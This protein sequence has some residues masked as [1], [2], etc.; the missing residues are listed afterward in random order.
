MQHYSQNGWWLRLMSSFSHDMQDKK[1]CIVIL[2]WKKL[3]RATANSKDRT[4]AWV[5]SEGNQM[6]KP[7]RSNH[8]SWHISENNI[9]AIS[10]PHNLIIALHFHHQDPY[11]YG[12]RTAL[13]ITI[14]PRFAPTHP[15]HTMYGQIELLTTS[16]THQA[17]SHLHVLHMLVRPLE[18]LIPPICPTSLKKPVNYSYLFPHFTV[19]IHFWL[20][21]ITDCELVDGRDTVSWSLFFLSTEQALIHIFLMVEP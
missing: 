10:L 6:F 16:Q 18:I 7:P 12:H 21:H 8:W 14:K 2:A 9:L 19:I 15:H 1:K 5:K 20:S 13:D 4:V 17:L 11:S 3:W